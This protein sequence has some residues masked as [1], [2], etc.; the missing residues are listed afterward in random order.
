MIQTETFQPRLAEKIRGFLCLGSHSDDHRN[1][2]WRPQ[3][4]PA[5][6]A[7]PSLRIPLGRLQ[8]DLACAKMK[9]RPCGPSLFCRTH[10][11]PR[12]SVEKLFPDGFM[13]V[14][15]AG[16]LKAIFEELKKD[17]RSRSDLHPLR[18]RT[19]HQ[20]HRQVVG[21]NLEHFPRPHVI[22]EYEIPKIRRRQ[23][24]SRTCFYFPA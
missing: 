4:P 9:A 15:W 8:C 7:I 2:M 14:C 10:G 6:P 1:W 3:I 21:I 23:W 16:E 22:L 17:C 13:A 11:T 19:P 18:Q 24:A 5:F 12:A 20:D